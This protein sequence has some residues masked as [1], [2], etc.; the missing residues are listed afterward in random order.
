MSLVTAHL[1]FLGLVDSMKT[2][3]DTFLVL[4][5][6]LVLPVQLLE[7]TLLFH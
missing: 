2:L 1:V 4:L 6:P 3:F 5:Q 7:L